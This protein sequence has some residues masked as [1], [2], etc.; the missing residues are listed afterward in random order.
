MH[1]KKNS[2]NGDEKQ[3]KLPFDNN[4]TFVSQKISLDN[5]VYFSSKLEKNNNSKENAARK[6]SIER[7]LYHA[8]KLDW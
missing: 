2:S 3:L 4:D 1:R 7:L 8:D 5:V 6:R